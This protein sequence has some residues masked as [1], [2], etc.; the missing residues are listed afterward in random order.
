[1]RYNSFVFFSYF[2]KETLSHLVFP[3]L[4]NTWTDSHLLAIL[5]IWSSLCWAHLKLQSHVTF[6]LSSFLPLSQSSCIRCWLDD[7]HPRNS[8]GVYWTHRTHGTLTHP[9]S[10]QMWEFKKKWLHPWIDIFLQFFFSLLR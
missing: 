9:Y 5:V 8:H 2:F 10:K 6:R 7:S 4:S 3:Y 1:M